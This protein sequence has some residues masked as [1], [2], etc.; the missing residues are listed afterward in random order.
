MP[1]SGWKST[2][3]EAQRRAVDH[4]G[5][6]LIVL[7]GP[8][9]GK[10]RTII[11]R[12]A[13]L[14]ENG[15]EPSSILALTF[16]VRA[17]EEIRS[18]LAEAVGDRTA[19]NVQAS[20]FHSFGWAV[21]RRFGDMVG[22]RQDAAIMDSAQEKR[23]LRS[24]IRMHGLFRAHAPS[25]YAAII[26]EARC[27]IA[28]CRHAAKTPGE[29]AK[30]AQ[31]WADIVARND[32]GLSGDELAAEKNRADKFAELSL[33]F[34]HF[35]EAC[36]ERN[37]VT[38]DDFLAL[39]L[40]LLAAKPIVGQVLRSEVRHV[41][42]DEF[43]DNN[44]AQIE[45][46]RYLFPPGGATP[47]SL[48]VV[49]DDDQAIYAFRG[50]DTRAFE[51]F[52]A[53]WREH[54]I[55]PL[56]ED[57]RSAPPIV[58]AA[59]RII[60]KAAE[61][62]VEGKSLVS[63]GDAA[64]VEGVVEG[65]TIANDDCGIAVASM[66]RED[67]ARTERPFFSYCVIARSNKYRDML[68][69]QLEQQ[70]IPVDVGCRA[71][72]AD[73]EGV[74]DL[75]AWLR[76]LAD[77]SDVQ[78][79][80]RVLI[81][82]PFMLDVHRVNAWRRTHERAQADAGQEGFADWLCREA[83][84]DPEVA[85]FASLLS[86]L[87]VVAAKEP[88]DRAV[89]HVTREAA[90]AGAEAL[91]PRERAKRIENIVQVIRFVR[92]VQPHL[93][94]PGDV[95]AFLAYYDDLDDKEQEFPLR[96]EDPLETEPDAHTARDCVRVITAHGAKGLEFDTVFVTRVRPENGGM[97][98]VKRDR[99]AEELPEAFTGSPVCDGKE[100]E[101]RL[102][103]VACTR[104]KRRLVLLAKPKKSVTDSTDYF[105]ELGRAAPPGEAIRIATGDAWLERARADVPD[106]LCR[107][108]DGNV[109]PAGRRAALFRHELSRLR[110]DAFAA[111][112]DAERDAASAMPRL[113]VAAATIS[114]VAHLRNAGA[115]PA[116]LPGHADAARLGAFVERLSHLGEEERARAP[117]PPLT[118]S[119]SRLHSY[120]TC[121]RC[122]FLKY[123]LGLDEPTSDAI[124][125]GSVAHA[126][127]EKYYAEKRDAE[128]DGRTA[129]GL[130]R[131]HAIAAKEYRR[132]WPPSRPYSETALEQLRAQLALV[133][134]RMEDGA[135]VRELEKFIAFPYTH[136]EHTHTIN[137][138][139]DRLDQ[140]QSGGW[141]IVDYKTGQAWDKLK[142]P[143]PDDL[144]LCLYAMAL[145]HFLGLSDDEPIDGV[146]EYWLLSSGDRGSLRFADMRLDKAR[147]TINE[148]IEGILAGRFERDKKCNG[149]CAWMG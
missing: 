92:Q 35:D 125:V 143:K 97:P 79:V 141:R 144:Q 66:I 54:T 31:E 83:G 26:E 30:Y 58:A 34:L 149:F 99:D 50:A 47:G 114:A 64:G 134:E 111:L 18:R 95:A 128:A 57:Y 52:K 145:P 40:K 93:D 147:K 43:Q 81:R 127:L 72:P 10:T 69:A 146:A 139:L 46:L 13:R 4:D 112:H 53:I 140:M 96:A 60:A 133:L 2:L 63:A 142:E 103:Y 1:D 29:A 67:R 55:V 120:A 70:G 117:K 28:D 41:L 104:A 51:R 9:T 44:A 84:A 42:V 113:S 80:F 23:L 115:L 102:F 148:S 82:P 20:T 17:A 86:E 135:D 106:A 36:R 48:C 59:N 122:Y 137:A 32:D 76:L 7:A 73:D 6:P 77:P 118:L 11:A 132:S 75:L 49:G 121:P 119:F 87:R 78:P 19:Q 108:L 91:E 15:V 136:G 3:N 131:L 56:T 65:V 110:Q 37:L 45:L 109:G 129:P 130:D 107:E 12:M 98:N 27:F 62:V 90:I 74:K 101:R 94:Q 89:E 138:K 124:Q 116:P 22:F 68:A 5:D 14:I 88:A 39:P 61:R 8:G 16:G 123:V 100:E 33:L 85:P 38:Y 24:L 71:T 126:A 25:G 21:L 105:D